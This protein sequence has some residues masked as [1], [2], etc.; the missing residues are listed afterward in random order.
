MLLKDAGMWAQYA[1]LM[2]ADFRLFDEFAFARA[3][4]APLSMPACCFVAEKDKKARARGVSLL[5]VYVLL[6]VVL[7]AF[8]LTSRWCYSYNE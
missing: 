5:V 7:L 3:G 2:R 1:P 8:S 6:V 4:E